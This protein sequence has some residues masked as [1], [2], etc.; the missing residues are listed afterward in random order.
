MNLYISGMELPE[1]C[2]KCFIGA[3]DSEC[4][5][6]TWYCPIT[7]EEI[8]E[9]CLSHKRSERCP[10][11]SVPDHGRLIDADVLRSKCNDPYWCVWMSDIDDSPSVIPADKD[12]E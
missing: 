4:I 9:N 11:I 5:Y 12:G 1:S 8:S 2:D 10:L 6:T 3:P 7:E